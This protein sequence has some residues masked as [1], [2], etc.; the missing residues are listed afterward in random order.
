M[1]LFQNLRDLCCDSLD[2]IG[3]NWLD[4]QV[5]RR[6]WLSSLCCRPDVL[7]DQMCCMTASC[8]GC[9]LVLLS[10]DGLRR[11]PSKGARATR[12]NLVRIVFEML[13]RPVKC[14]AFFLVPGPLGLS[15][16]LH[17]TS[18]GLFQ[19]VPDHWIWGCSFW[20]FMFFFTI[21]LVWRVCYFLLIW[22]NQHGVISTGGQSEVL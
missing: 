13:K 17:F 5:R 21:K 8:S 22:P 11:S 14:C 19:H 9:C 1:A 2:P 12:L 7:H 3:S 10:A 4:L 6:R 18:E 20:I 15:N 16:L